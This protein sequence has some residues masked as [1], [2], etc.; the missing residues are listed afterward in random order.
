VVTQHISSW[1]LRV[2]LVE[3]IKLGLE[4]KRSLFRMLYV[5]IQISPDSDHL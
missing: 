2:Q 1:D 3:R 5:G 4:E